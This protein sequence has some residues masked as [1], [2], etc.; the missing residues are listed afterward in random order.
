MVKPPKGNDNQAAP[1]ERCSH[2][3]LNS[4]AMKGSNGF[5]LSYLLLLVSVVTSAQNHLLESFKKVYPKYHYTM[6][7]D[8]PFSDAVELWDSGQTRVPAFV[9][10]LICKNRWTRRWA[11]ATMYNCFN[12]E[13][14]KVME[15]GFDSYWRQYNS[16]DTVGSYDCINCRLST[17]VGSAIRDSSCPYYDY[18]DNKVLYDA[19]CEFNA[20]VRDIGN[21]K[22]IN[23]PDTAR[24]FWFKLMKDQQNWRG[25]QQYDT[26]KG[27]KVFITTSFTS[28]DSASIA[29]Q[30]ERLTI[31]LNQ[32]EEIKLLYFRTGFDR[33]DFSNSFHVLSELKHKFILDWYILSNDHT[34]NIWRSLSALSNMTELT[35]YSSGILPE[36]GSTKS[37]LRFIKFT[38]F[39][40]G[41]Q[42]SSL[43]GFPALSHIQMPH[44]KSERFP[45]ELLQLSN[46]KALYVNC[47]N[48]RKI[49]FRESNLDSLEILFLDGVESLGRITIREGDL[50]NLKILLVRK[51]NNLKSISGLHYLQGLGTLGVSGRKKFPKIIKLAKQLNELK[52]LGISGNYDYSETPYKRFRYTYLPD[53]DTEERQKAEEDSGIGEWVGLFNMVRLK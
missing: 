42:D 6:L 33:E 46:L 22:I 28:L 32:V 40:Y 15:Y 30:L 47:P 1:S 37:N 45:S 3:L 52:Y 44:L 43:S 27:L 17:L 16:I 12:K 5:I 41:L 18:G 48:V 38:G 24:T 39:I 7:W 8:E 26:L 49:D 36:V 11:S 51:A 9:D 23:Y 13:G 21:L 14:K 4:G 31:T 19:A 34:P 29:R 2:H 35:F 25:L 53:Y 10:T 20:V 50:P